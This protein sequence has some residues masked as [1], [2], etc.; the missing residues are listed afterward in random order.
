MAKKKKATEDE[1][2]EKDLRT[3]VARDGAYVM[4]LFITL[5]A[6][7][8]GCVF[9]YLDFEEYGQ[10]KAPDVKAPAISKLGDK[11]PPD[12]RPAPAPAPAPDPAAGGGA[13][14]PGGGM[15]MGGMPMGMMP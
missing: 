15:P 13:A 5:V 14:A 1:K 11:A 2:D 7:I 10:Q 9:M 6:V 4:M 12:T 3:P 8:A